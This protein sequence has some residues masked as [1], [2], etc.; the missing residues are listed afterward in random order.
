MTH[1]HGH[2]GEEDG[3]L[4]ALGRADEEQVD[5]IMHSTFMVCL[6]RFLAAEIN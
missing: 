3:G 6:D 4:T 1:I 5:K 2:T